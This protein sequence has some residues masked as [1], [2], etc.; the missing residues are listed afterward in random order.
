[1]IS[2]HNY[3]FDCFCL[4]ILLFQDSTNNHHS[5]AWTMKKSSM[6]SNKYIVAESGVAAWIC[7]HHSYLQEKHVQELSWCMHGV[8]VLLMVTLFFEITT[9]FSTT[10]TSI[11][12]S[13]ICIG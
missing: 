6:R 13:S 10:F 1:M 5:H 12:D 7:H 8:L 11:L 4:C 2:E 9:S 3:S